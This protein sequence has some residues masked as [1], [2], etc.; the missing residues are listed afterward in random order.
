[1]IKDAEEAEAV[2]NRLNS[3]IE[4]TGSV[5]GFTATQLAD[6]ASELAAITTYDDDAI[7]GAMTL[8]ATFKNIR[9]DQFKGATKAVMDMATVMGGDL[10]GTAMQVS[11][12]LNDPLVGLSALS[13]AGVTFTEQQRAQIEAMMKVNDVAGAQ[14]IILA[15]LRS[16][17][18]GAAEGELNTT[19]GKFKQLEN[20][21][22]ELKEAIGGALLPYVDEL[23][24]KLNEVVS[25]SDNVDAATAKTAEGIDYLAD[26]VKAFVLLM[27]S[28]WLTLQATM[29]GVQEG[30][31]AVGK[32][33]EWIGVLSEDTT[34]TLRDMADASY[35]AA[36]A[37][38]NA[39]AAN[40]DALI[41]A[42]IVRRNADTGADSS[43][44]G[45]T[46]SFGEDPIELSDKELEKRKEKRETQKF[47]ENS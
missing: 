30:N 45:T 7:K 12:A 16:E 22:G 46:E 32:G 40:A 39:I 8:I 34:Q 42:P 36:D 38:A 5:A 17:F 41:N 27:Q 24:S 11:K 10:K 14:R 3:V 25:S 21:I 23:V 9:G 6:M 26:G 44:S 47:H 43:A 19:A 2:Q 37:T 28:L 13:K 31:F 15:E 4:A 20:N 18:G 35:A 33:L 29:W 1:M